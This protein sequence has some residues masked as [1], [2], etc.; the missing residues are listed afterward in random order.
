MVAPFSLYF[1]FRYVLDEFLYQTE[2][3]GYAKQ[4]DWFKLD[5]A[6]SRD[7][8]KE[9]VY[10]QDLVAQTDDARLLLRNGPAGLLYVL[11]TNFHLQY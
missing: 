5:T 1:G 9:K 6:F 4:C 3:E 11:C 2:L 10:V 7:D 8:P